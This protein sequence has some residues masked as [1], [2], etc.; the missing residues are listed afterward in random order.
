M[1]H[2]LGALLAQRNDK[3]FK[4]VVYCL[5]QTLVG[6]ECCY[7]P[8]EKECLTLVFAMQ[9][10]RHYLVR[11]EIHVIS[12]VNPLWI[13]IRKPRSLNSR[14]ANWG[15]LLSQCNMT[16]IPQKAMK[17]QAFVYFL[18]A[19]QVFKTFKL[20]ETSQMRSLKST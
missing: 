3:G 11:Q 7:N 2:S 9:K 4:Q 18:A 1:D 16:F 15:I 19:D 13:L 12:R 5:S 14:L 8:V 17:G 10:I 20:H 6:A